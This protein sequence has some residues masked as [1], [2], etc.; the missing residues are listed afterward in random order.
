MTWECVSHG[1]EYVEG[2]GGCEQSI[3]FNEDE[4]TAPEPPKGDYPQ[5]DEPKE[6]WQ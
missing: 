5:P 6:P 4:A 3:D 1:T 2:C